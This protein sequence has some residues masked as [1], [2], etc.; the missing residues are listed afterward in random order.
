MCYMCAKKKSRQIQATVI[1]YRKAFMFQCEFDL[2]FVKIFTLQKV[3][4]LNVFYTSV[5]SSANCTMSICN[6]VGAFFY[7]LFCILFS[8][9]ICCLFFHMLTTSIKIRLNT[10]RR[11]KKNNQQRDERT[12][13]FF[14]KQHQ[15]QQ[16]K[17]QRYL[18]T[19][20]YC[21]CICLCME[22]IPYKTHMAVIGRVWLKVKTIK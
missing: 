19:F 15:P 10:T 7:V 13:F 22:W 1:I 17:S 4:N 12:Y 2:S 11:E 14:L 3:S 21:I 8:I 20:I 5:I 16:Y 6:L 18:F 9:E